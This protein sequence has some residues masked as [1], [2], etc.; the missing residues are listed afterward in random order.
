MM[1]LGP[2]NKFGALFVIGRV[3]MVMF[4]VSDHLI[5]TDHT[6]ILQPRLPKLTAH[7]I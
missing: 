4:G 3:C 2:L 6:S 1:I 5:Q 7:L